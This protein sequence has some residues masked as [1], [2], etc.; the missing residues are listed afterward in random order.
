MAKWQEKYKTKVVSLDE[1]LNKVKDNDQIIC[2]L[3]GSEPR[4]ILNN[5]HKIADR[6][7][8]VRVVNC[9]PM[10]NYEY[11]ANPQYKKSFLTESWF[12][13]PGLRKAHSQGNVTFIPQH[14]H[15]ALSKRL[16]HRKCNIFMGTATPPDRHGNMSLSLGV[17]YERELMKQADLVILQVNERLPRTFGD[18]II[19]VSDV[20]YVVLQTED[21]PIL[22]V[23]QPDE[24][25]LL[26]GKYIAEMVDDGCTI[27]LGIG[28]IPN[29]VAKELINKKDL[30]IHTEM[31]VDGMIDLIEAG[32]ING[33][34]KTLLPEKI[35]CTFALGTSRLYDYLNDNPGVVFMNGSWVND[36]YVIGQ[37][38]K[39]ISI[40]GTLEVDLTG[41]CCSESLGHRQF[42]GTGGNSDTAVGAQI[43]SGGKSF[44][45]LQSTAE[46]K[47]PA[48]G[49]KKL[50]SKIV[51]SLT[52]GSIVSLSRN[53]VD[54]VVTEY[55]IAALRG[56]SVR[57]RVERLSAI[58]HPGFRSWLIEE[59][60]GLMIW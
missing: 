29:A 14:L 57:E 58:A 31:F 13:S 25:D 19:S 18:T 38:Y 21:L 27:Q 53:D 11:Y 33:K 50:V 34:R 47:D 49:E 44:I 60:K 54:F 41:Q 43:S 5:L 6:V 28:G 32:V 51:P 7:K 40:N 24:K 46:V 48:T 10:G 1:A 8:N 9:L 52:P 59:S 22:P 30:G 12:Y 2:A 56:T 17:T 4:Y 39:Q 20:D 23:D 26:I 45:A 16:V 36:P 37:N 55:G 15:L 35:V 3:G 42:S